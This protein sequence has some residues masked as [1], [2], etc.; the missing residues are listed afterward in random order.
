MKDLEKPVLISITP[1]TVVKAILIVLLFW[2][3]FVMKDLVLVLLTS[4]V[5]ASAVEPATRFFTK[6]KIPRVISVLAVYLFVV[7]L[8]SGISYFFLPALIQDTS[9]V[10][11]RVPGYL[12]LIKT[13]AGKI[14]DIP[15]IQDFISVLAENASASEVI[16]RIG[17]GFS[18]ATFGFFTTASAVF[19]GVLS[20]ILIIVLSFYLAVQEDGVTNFLRIVTPIN[21][22]KYVIDLWKRSQRKIGLWM[23]GQLLLGVLVGVMTYLGLSV[24]GIENALFLALVAAVFELIPL[25]GPILASVPAVAFALLQGGLPLGLLIIGLY[26]II[27]QFESQLIHP[28]VVTKIVGIPA[29]VAIISIIIGG[30]LAGFL[31][32]LISVPIAAAI[33]EYLGDVEKR[34]ISSTAN[35]K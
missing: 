2:F 16:S 21:H 10:L 1:G 23:Q 22:E 32:I 28:L 15:A 19:G 9:D 11:N 13:N 5:I 20:F 31:G 26:V 29:L 34:K 4:V 8:L 7:L 17:G 27:Q 25:F 18:G 12:E 30:Q 24:L 35:S 33:M 3:L 6:F 14:G